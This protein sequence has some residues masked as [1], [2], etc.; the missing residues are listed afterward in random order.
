ME[1]YIWFSVAVELGNEGSRPGMNLAYD[2]I[3]DTLSP[4]QLVQ[5]NSEVLRRKIAIRNRQAQD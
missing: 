2:S 3:R 5:A 4:V 1:A